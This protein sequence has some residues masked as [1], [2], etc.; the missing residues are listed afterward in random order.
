MIKVNKA[1]LPEAAAFLRDVGYVPPREGSV[2]MFLRT[3]VGD[4]VLLVIEEAT[5]VLLVLRHDKTAHR[6][7]LR[8]AAKKGPADAMD[9]V[10]RAVR[11]GFMFSFPEVVTD[12][13]AERLRSKLVTFTNGAGGTTITWRADLATEVTNE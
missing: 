8:M 2:D 12:V 5:Q 11:D 3:C 10:Y 1:T 4:D 9:V 13:P 7:H 6:T